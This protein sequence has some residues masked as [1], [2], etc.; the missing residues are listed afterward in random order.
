MK[1]TIG[2]QEITDNDIILIFSIFF[3]SIAISILSFQIFYNTNI[4]WGI[5]SSNSVISSICLYSSK[6]KKLETP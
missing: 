4:T 2:K 5:I 6:I 3:G 1:L